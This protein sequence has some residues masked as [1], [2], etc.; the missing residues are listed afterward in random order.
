MAESLC[1]S[2]DVA[3]PSVQA[4]DTEHTTSVI[5][6]EGEFPSYGT[7]IEPR[8][9]EFTTTV[10]QGEPMRIRSSVIFSGVVQ[11]TGPEK[12]EHRLNS[13]L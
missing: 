12:L 9:V 8:T 6:A 1:R 10:S 7:S 13:A 2:K 5:V 11:L 4:I 3:Q